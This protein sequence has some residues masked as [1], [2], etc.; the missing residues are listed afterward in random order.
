MTA[1]L[2]KLRNRK[3]AG[4]SNISPEMLKVGAKNEDFVSMLTDLFRQCGKKQEYHM[5]GWRLFSSPSS[6][7]GICTCATIG[8]A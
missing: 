2:G 5:S 4:I 1:A 7:K 8:E 6:R 3:A